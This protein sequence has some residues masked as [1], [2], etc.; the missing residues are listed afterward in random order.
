VFLTQDLG[1]RMDQIGGMLAPESGPKFINGLLIDLAS[2]GLQAEIFRDLSRIVRELSGAVRA[3]EGMID[4]DGG[5]YRHSV[6][7]VVGVFC[8]HVLAESALRIVRW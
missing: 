8:Q 2:W 6:D 4:A 3:I 5:K 1:A 7:G